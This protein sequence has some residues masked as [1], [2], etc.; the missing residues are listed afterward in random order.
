[1]VV[2]I[3]VHDMKDPEP[4]TLDLGHLALFVGYAF[5]GAV[6]ERIAEAGFEGLRFSHGFV[7]QHLIDGERTIGEL[8]ERLEVTQQAASKTVAELEALGYL[9]RVADPEDARIHR[10]RLSARGSAVVAATRKARA[11]LERKLEARH[12]ARGVAAARA[13]LAGVLDS[14]GGVEAVRGRRVLPPR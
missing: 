12:G 2:N 13:V 6:Q 10:V 5:A 11:A 7:V 8:A 3:M 1:M 4:A 9:E 14:L